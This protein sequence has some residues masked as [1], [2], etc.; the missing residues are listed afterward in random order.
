MHSWVLLQFL[1]ITSYNA[2]YISCPRSCSCGGKEEKAFFECNQTNMF[3]FP[4]LNEIP[5]ATKQIYLQNN[6]IQHLP[7][8][9]GVRVK[10]WIIDIS[11]NKIRNIEG[12]HLGRIFPKLSTLDLSRNQI[13]RVT[14]DSFF[15]LNR[16][17][18]LNLAYNQISFVE[19][20]AFDKLQRLMFL[21]LTFNQISHL[22]FR[23]FKSLVSLNTISLA[24]NT[25]QGTLNTRYKWPASVKYVNLNN[26]KIR[27]IPKIPENAKSFNLMGNPLNCGCKSK[28]FDLESISRNTLCKINMRCQSGFVINGKCINDKQS[29]YI[30]KFWQGFSEK[31]QCLKSSIKELT[32]GY[33][34]HGFPYLRCVASGIPAPNISLVHNK[35]KQQVIVPGLEKLNKTSLTLSNEHL[36]AGIYHCKANNFFS[37]TGDRIKVNTNMIQQNVMQNDV[38]EEVKMRRTIKI[39]N[40]TSQPPFK[41]DSPPTPPTPKPGKSL[42]YQR[43]IY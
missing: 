28:T 35:T 8:E 10:V 6:Q 36:I 25:I 5:E 18:N 11:G 20:H 21:N 14:V 19:E 3:Y 15:N 16:L 9:N 31:E 22:N 30:Y 42:T 26:N 7:H 43:I 1:W 24:H 29:D 34:K 32:F 4:H 39:L 12:N 27:I 41:S 40:V 13:K 2:Q 33:D 37:D 17:N 38:T 23:W